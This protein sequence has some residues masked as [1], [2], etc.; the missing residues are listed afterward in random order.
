MVEG[1]E[2]S[3]LLSPFFFSPTYHQKVTLHSLHSR[4]AGWPHSSHACFTP[5][6]SA[7]GA[8]EVDMGE[9]G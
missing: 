7:M 1:M 3:T 4:V 2:Q 6:G 9:G 5:L 8:M